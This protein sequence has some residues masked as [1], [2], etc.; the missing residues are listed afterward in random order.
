[1]NEITAWAK[2]EEAAL[3]TIA[4]QRD[5]LASRYDLASALISE[6]RQ[7]F[8]SAIQLTG[9]I[10]QLETKTREMTITEVTEG[11]GTIGQSMKDLRFTL[12]RSYTETIEETVDATEALV[13]NFRD[14]AAKARTFAD[15]LRILR[16]MGLDPQLFGQLVQAGVEAG[17]ETAQALVDGGSDT[18]NEINTLFEEIDALG[19]SL[20]E[21]V[22]TSL[23]GTGIDMA[24]GLLKG[25]LAR[26]EALEAAARDMAET[27]NEAFQDAINVA[28]DRAAASAQM[29]VLTGELSALE[30]EQQRILDRIAENQEVLT[31]GTAGPGARDWAEIKLDSYLEQLEAINEQIQNANSAIGNA[32]GAINADLNLPSSASMMSASAPQ[33]VVNNY[34]VNVTADTRVGGSKAGEAVVQQL[35]QYEFRNGPISSVLTVN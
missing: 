8:T 29:P 1:M 23:Y 16:D 27:F 11:V 19:S 14:V 32:Q 26:Q 28:T 15:N 10:G 30:Q 3:S 13:N 25:I 7:A 5:D 9:I 18:I 33:P 20:G 24:D 2:A 34:N 6:Y 4:K 21:E 35:K 22:A 12:T 31:G 17:G